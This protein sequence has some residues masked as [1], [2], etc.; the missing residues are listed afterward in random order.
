MS[1]AIRF[2]LLAVGLVAFVA[3]GG[4]SLVFTPALLASIHEPDPF[5]STRPLIADT[6]L[7]WPL[8]L[9]ISLSGFWLLQGAWLRDLSASASRWPLMGAG[10]FFLMSAG[11]IAVCAAMGYL[12]QMLAR[13]Q[14]DDF[15]L[16]VFVPLAAL[17]L[18]IVALWRAINRPARS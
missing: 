9:A 10:I 17:I 15:V 18:G 5:T 8:G 14:I 3:P 7:L 12:P 6:L 13:H 16:T 11:S 4:C 2:A 1:K